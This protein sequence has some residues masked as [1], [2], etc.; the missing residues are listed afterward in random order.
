MKITA[1][2]SII[3]AVVFALVC[4]GFAITGFTSLG[5]ITDAQQLA[6]AKGFAWFW[7]FLGAVGVLFGLVGMWLVKT[8]PQP[9]DVS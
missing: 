7:A 3:I 4:F 2:M 5:D 9:G 1:Q 8:S 6:D